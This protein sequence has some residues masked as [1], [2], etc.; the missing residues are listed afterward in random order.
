MG[1]NESTFTHISPPADRPAEFAAYS[2]IL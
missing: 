1:Y 2:T